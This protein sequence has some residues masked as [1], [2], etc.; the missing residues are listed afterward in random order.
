MH[1]NVIIV[2]EWPLRTGIY[3]TIWLMVFKPALA[4]VHAKLLE[5]IQKY[6]TTILCKVPGHNAPDICI[7]LHTNT[8][9]KT[10]ILN[11]AIDL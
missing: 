10:V 9:S 1:N 2:T 5:I 4:T 6:H 8:S 3:H 7:G 11:V